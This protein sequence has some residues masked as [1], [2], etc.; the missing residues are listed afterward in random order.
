[1]DNYSDVPYEIDFGMLDGIIDFLTSAGKTLFSIF[2]FFLAIY[3]TFVTAFD[4]FYINFP[5]VQMIASKYNLDGSLDE[6]KLKIRVISRDAY[7]AVLEKESAGTYK[8]INL[9][10]LRKRGATYLKLAIIMSFL[11]A[12]PRL[13]IP[14]GG[15]L[16]KPIFQAFGIM[17]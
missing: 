1:M 2:A 8:N 17:K 12:G 9:V 5:A 11:V 3:V 10:Y 16:L 4:I 7:K 15:A 6:S 13:L 14:L